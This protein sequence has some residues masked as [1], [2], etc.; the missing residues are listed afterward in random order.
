MC[1]I[2]AAIYIP[3]T[4]SF[5]KNVP[6]KVGGRERLKK[7]KGSRE[8][9]QFAIAAEARGELARDHTATPLYCIMT[10]LRMGLSFSN[11]PGRV[12]IFDLS[13]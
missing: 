6:L 1:G 10:A 13:T 3:M 12:G 8:V 11:L 5:L 2:K 9:T 4:T 7:K